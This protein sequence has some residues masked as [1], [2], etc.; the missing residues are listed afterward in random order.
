M[1]E[2]SSSTVVIYYVRLSL[3][4]GLLL[5][6]DFVRGLPP[7]IFGPFAIASTSVV[8]AMGVDDRKREDRIANS[9]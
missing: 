9:D 1:P 6:V 8:G 7:P 4:L 3:E 2:R 5:T